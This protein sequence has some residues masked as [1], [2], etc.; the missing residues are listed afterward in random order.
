MQNVAA[1]WYQ[2]VA[3]VNDRWEHAMSTLLMIALAIAR[4]WERE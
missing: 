1:R 2:D 3:P 4:R